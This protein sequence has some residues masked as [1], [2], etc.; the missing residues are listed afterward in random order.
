MNPHYTIRAQ[1]VGRMSIT[2]FGQSWLTV[3]F[4]GRILPGDVGKRIYKAMDA[5]GGFYLQVEND[6]QR[7]RREGVKNA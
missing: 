6:Q 2:A 3:N 1:D 7:A 5:S 4:I